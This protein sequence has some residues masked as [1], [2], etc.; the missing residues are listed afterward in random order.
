MMKSYKKK[1]KKKRLI[2]MFPDYV[3]Y[4][5]IEKSTIRDRKRLRKCCK[6]FERMFQIWSLTNTIK[7]RRKVGNEELE[8]F[9]RYR[10]LDLSST[11]VTDISPLAGTPIQKLWLSLTDITDIN[12]LAGTPIHELFINNT[13]VTDISSLAGTPIHVLFLNN[14]GV[15]DISSLAGTPIQ[16][17][18][19]RDTEITD[20]SMLHSDVIL[21]C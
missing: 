11:R 3:I 18:Y 19:F 7:L 5:I 10:N 4:K 13:Q 9:K 20:T 12:A 14:T 2:K 1:N 15:T 17:L 16:V 6:Q 8:L 21:R